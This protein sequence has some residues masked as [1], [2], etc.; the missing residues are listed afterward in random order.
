M[1]AMP[2]SP[3]M[4]AAGPPTGPS[5]ALVHDITSA[6]SKDD[7]YGFLTLGEGEDAVEYPILRKPSP[8][9][10]VEMARHEA[11]GSAESIG[12]AGD[13]LEQCLGSAGYAAFRA[14][15][16]Q[17]EDWDFEDLQKVVQ[18]VIEAT[19]ARPT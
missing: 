14:Q 15:S 3:A 13:L 12:L 9:L 6:K 19:V 17:I 16:Y 11:D 2:T 8:L 4:A 10:I 7:G 1:Q 18:T 5:P